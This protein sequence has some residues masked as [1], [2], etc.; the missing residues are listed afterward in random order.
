MF[1]FKKK[2][3][4]VASVSPNPFKDQICVRTLT[5][6]LNCIWEIYSVN[7][8]LFCSG[9]LNNVETKINS[10]ELPAGIYFLKVIKEQIQI[11]KL[12]KME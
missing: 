3:S 8:Q 12:I 11:Y 10:E 4:Q 7:G 5:N 1:L 2:I 9:N 6:D